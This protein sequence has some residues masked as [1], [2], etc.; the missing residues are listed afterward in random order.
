MDKVE[1][2]DKVE[3]VET[4]ECS[5]DVEWKGRRL[6]DGRSRELEEK[7]EMEGEQNE[8]TVEPESGRNAYGKL[9]ATVGCAEDLTLCGWLGPWCRAIW[10]TLVGQLE[11]RW[12][13]S[14]W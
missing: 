12:I 4:Q 7:V 10:G 6:E 11:S 8:K 3:K 9:P 14:V 5:V 1:W 2:E 13:P